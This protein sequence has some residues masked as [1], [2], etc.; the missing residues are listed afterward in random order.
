MPFKN[1][2]DTTHELACALAQLVDGEFLILGEP[3]PAPGRRRKP[4]TKPARPAPARYVQVLRIEGLLSAE[5][6]GAT[7]FG[8]TWEMD[9]PTIT[10]LRAMGWK[11]PAE[12]PAQYGNITPNFDLYVDPQGLSAL[13]DLLVASLQVLGTRPHELELVIP[14]A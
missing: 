1:W 7:A 4:F 3:A 6:V 10:Q 9:T 14:A 11:T 8:G 12:S 13:T 2:D 5:C